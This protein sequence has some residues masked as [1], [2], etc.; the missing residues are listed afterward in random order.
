MVRLLSRVAQLGQVGSL[1]LLAVALVVVE[2]LAHALVPAVSLLAGLLVLVAVARTRTVSTRSLTML[3]S[4]S[5]VWALGIAVL[6]TALGNAEGLSA[7][8]DGAMISLAA[9]VEEPGKLLILLLPALVAPGRMRRMA[10]S[11]W[12]LMGYA[13]GAGFTIAEDSVRRLTTATN[14]WSILAELF[15]EGTHYSLNPLTSGSLER[16]LEAPFTG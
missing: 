10:A 8:D 9:F 1:L 5:T 15:D 11:D 4:A 16:G 12:A 6:T 3:L 13:A 14:L 2:G 7:R